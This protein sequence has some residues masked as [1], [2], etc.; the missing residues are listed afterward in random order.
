MTAYLPCATC[1]HPAEQHLH[2]PRDADVPP[3]LANFPCS[4]AG[5]GCDDYDGFAH[6]ERPPLADA[7][8]YLTNEGG[9]GVA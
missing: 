5:C 7:V 6:P 1:E 8:I 9:I 2:D 4:T 3:V